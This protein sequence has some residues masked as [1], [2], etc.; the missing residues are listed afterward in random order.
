MSHLHI[1]L[2][3]YRENLQLHTI[4]L[5]RLYE[6]GTPY[7]DQFGRRIPNYGEDN[8]FES[9]KIWTSFEPQ[10]RR[11]NYEDLDWTAHSFLDP[12]LISDVG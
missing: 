7:L 6:D 9:S 11:G 4:G 12:L 2:H 3:L 10:I 1:A 8:I 5:D